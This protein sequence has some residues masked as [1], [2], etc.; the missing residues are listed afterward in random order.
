MPQHEDQHHVEDGPDVGEREA[1]EHDVPAGESPSAHDTDV[2]HVLT[3]IE[4]EL[5]A[6]VERC[7]QTTAQHAK[8]LTQRQAEI[9]RTIQIAMKR[10]VE[11]DRQTNEL[12]SL[13]DEV[14]KAESKLTDRRRRLAQKLRRRREWMSARTTAAVDTHA[15]EAAEE[16]EARAQELAEREASLTVDSDAIK[17]EAE[18]VQQELARLA[19]IRQLV[20]DQAGLT[21]EHAQSMET[22]LHK[23]EQASLE[24]IERLSD[25]C[26]LADRVRDLSDQVREG[27]LEV[28]E[29]NERAGEAEHEAAEARSALDAARARIAQLESRVEG[30]SREKL[31]LEQRSLRLE[32][33]LK[34]REGR[35][36]KR[37]QRVERESLRLADDQAACDSKL[38]ELG[39]KMSE[40]ERRER[41]RRL[42]PRT[43]LATTS[44]P[45]P[46]SVRRRPELRLV[47]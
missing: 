2:D 39:H 40:S 36:A 30:L 6:L 13:A 24:L 27:R 22:L 25:A 38:R 29:S 1:C 8:E 20:E 31:L 12:R 5:S 3:S 16:M 45:L 35:L 43:P 18:V 42:D 4:Q 34:T 44:M 47:N 46:V 37:E 26:G 15:R 21:A 32:D 11:I 19:E 9:D 41:S 33:D 23:R 28:R 7:E 14:V 10:Q 17:A